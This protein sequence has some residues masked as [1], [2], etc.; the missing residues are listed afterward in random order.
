MSANGAGLTRRAALLAPLALTACSKTAAGFDGGWLGASHERGHRLREATAFTPAATRR[1]AVAIVGA[2][3]AGLAAARALALAGIDDVQVFELESEAGGN[4][5][6]HTLGGMACPL[7]AHY[8][9]LPGPEAH[10]V[11]DWLH[12]IGL[13]KRVAG[14]S[15]PEERHLCHSPQERLWVDGQWLDGLL[16]PA[17]RGS[18][19][20]R[21]YRRFAQL[22]A[23][24]SRTL[25]FAIPT[26]RAGWSAGL[27]ALDALPFAA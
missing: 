21:Q 4:A 26:R 14:R 18:A 2:G 8:L 9:P 25:R 6:G 1:C 7:G 22:V 24:A 20:D 27:A 12:E 19:R 3:V 23:E 10:E 13:L 17:G 11:S 15:V 5:R 16:P